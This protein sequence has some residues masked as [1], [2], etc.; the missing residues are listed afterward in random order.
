MLELGYPCPEN[1]ASMEKTSCGNYCTTCAKEI[2]DFREKTNE[3]TKRILEADKSISCGI[4]RPDQMTHQTVDHVSSLFRIAFAAV[5][6]FGFNMN[7]LFAQNCEPVCT[8]K[9]DVEL[10]KSESISITGKVYGVEANELV[11]ATISFYIGDTYYNVRSDENGYFDLKVDPKIIGKEL[12]VTFSY[13]GLEGESIQFNPVQKGDYS[14][15]VNL[16]EYEYLRG[17]VAL[18]GMIRR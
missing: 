5:F 10:V 12:N 7:V 13:P 16:T 11:G 1:V 2:M 4:F 14:L 8:D 18:P 6:I 17:K 9:I 3:E 15:S